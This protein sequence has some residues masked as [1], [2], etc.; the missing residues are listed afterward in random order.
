MNWEVRSKGI[1]HGFAVY[2]VH[3]NGKLVKD[4]VL[5]DAAM[6]CVFSDG[7]DAETWGEFSQYAVNERKVYYAHFGWSVQRFSESRQK[8][9]HM[10]WE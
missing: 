3:H 7:E 5:L 6:Q 1:V 10:R 8:W 4:N 2:T 9:I